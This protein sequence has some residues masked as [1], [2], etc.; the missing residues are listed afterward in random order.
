[1]LES[2]PLHVIGKNFSHLLFNKGDF[3]S[4][5]ILKIVGIKK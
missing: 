3:N 5:E 2:S 4:A 1:M